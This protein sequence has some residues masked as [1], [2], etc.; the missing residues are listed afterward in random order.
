VTL[1]DS[2]S[3][4]AEAAEL[5]GAAEFDTA[6][7]ELGHVLG[8]RQ[9]ETVA[10]GALVGAHAAAG[11]PLDQ[12]VGYPGAV[13]H[14]DPG[15]ALVVPDADHR[16]VL[17]P[18]AG[19]VEQVPQQL[20]KVFAVQVQRATGA[21]VEVDGEIALGV[22]A[23]HR[24]DQIGHVLRGVEQ[25]THLTDARQSCPTK[26]ALDQ[27]ADA[28]GLGGDGGSIQC[29]LVVVDVVGQQAKGAFERMGEVAQRVAG[30]LQAQGEKA[31]YPVWVNRGQTTVSNQPKTEKPWS[32]PVF[33]VTW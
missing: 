16:T 4:N 28:L 24:L 3:L 23:A 27:Q 29:G 5:V 6:A 21:V 15:L 7:V 2:K 13:V 18:F 32:V 20:E 25:L 8:D 22:D 12:L 33:Q 19:I 31:D 30:S 1:F 17:S 14:A 11:E 26:L 9:P 10:F